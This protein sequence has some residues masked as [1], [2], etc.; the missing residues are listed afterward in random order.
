MATLRKVT[1]YLQLT[2]V[3]EPA[4]E[5]GFTVICPEFAIASQ[6]ESVDEAL[7]N[8]ED[9]AR[10]YIE[11]LAEL[12]DLGRI[13]RDRGVTVHARRPLTPISA[14]ISPGTVVASFITLCNL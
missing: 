12:G 7:A 13:L 8:I 14:E 5:G 11:T 1:G 3:A 9:A 2:A 6:G 4:P 10:L